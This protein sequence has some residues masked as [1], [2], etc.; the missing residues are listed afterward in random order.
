MDQQNVSR[1]SFV[2]QSAAAVGTAAL[3]S[4][5][6]PH[7]YAAGSGTIKIGLVGSGGRG[8]GA[9]VNALNAGKDIKLVAMAD[10]FADRLALSLKTLHGQKEVASRIDV[11]KE[12]QYVGFDAYKD[13]IDQVDVVLLT[14]TPRF[15]PQQLQYAVEK[16]KHIFAEKPVA[17]DPTSLRQMWETCQM[18]KQ[19]GLALVSGLC[20]RYHH[21]KQETM[22]RVLDGQIGDIIAVE[23][24]YNTGTLWY[25]GHKPEWS[26]M[27][28]QVRNWLYYTWLSGDHICEQA[29]H[30]LDKMGW[31]M[32]DQPPTLAWG[33]GGRQV[34]TGKEYGNIYDHFSIVYEYPNGTRGY[35]QCRQ[36][37]GCYNRV[38]DYIYGTKGVA[39][40]FTH[41]IKG[42]KPWKYKGPNN[43]MYDTEH[44]E[45][46]RSI[47]EGKPI[48]NGD[49]MCRSTGLAMLGRTV[50]Y[51]GKKVKW[52]E[53]WNS[54]EDLGPKEL[55]WGPAPQWPVAMPGQTKLA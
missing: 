25:R 26:E 47:R 35:H 3:A 18:A 49:Y 51:T 41:E 29:I 37:A 42:E 52:D 16:G 28:N 39:G 22:K 12:R 6:A 1:R 20:W 14:T 31:A 45:L 15:R 40:M 4:Q 43:N 48:Y 8:T 11:P 27:E 10:T 32:H 24:V 53:M 38:D 23:T 17:T 46:F 13:V 9:A 21:P 44:V 54:N 55:K 36:M 50:A 7:A 30:S 5:L 34:R 2:K 19:K 33:V